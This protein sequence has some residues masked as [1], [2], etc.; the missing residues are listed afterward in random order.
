MLQNQF[1]SYTLC[2]PLKPIRKHITTH[3][4]EHTTT[5]ECC[6]H[7][8]CASFVIIESNGDQD[9][10]LVSLQVPFAFLVFLAS[11]ILIYCPCR[12]GV[13]VVVIFLVSQLLLQKDNID[14]NK[15]QKHNYNIKGSILSNSFHIHNCLFFHIVEFR[16]GM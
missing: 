3:D 1:Y 7:I 2:F 5:D 14:Y 8:S 4:R 10:K 11:N 16:Q 13:D 12:K 9:S 6:A 15:W